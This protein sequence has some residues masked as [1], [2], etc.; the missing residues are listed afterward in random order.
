MPHTRTTTHLP[1]APPTPS[2]TIGEATTACYSTQEL[3]RLL[4]VDASTLRRW[5]TAR[6]PQGPPFIRL[7]PR[8]IV[9]RACDVQQ[10]LAN[11]RID[12]ALA[13]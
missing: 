1:T 3:A 10:W 7:S 8:R 5:R 2:Q 9:Y 4:G 12:P 13:A 11:H 6:P